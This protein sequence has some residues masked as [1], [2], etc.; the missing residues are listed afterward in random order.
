MGLEKEKRVDNLAKG[1]REALLDVCIGLPEFELCAVRD[2]PHELT[3]FPPGAPGVVPAKRNVAQVRQPWPDS[4]EAE[5]HER[6][7]RKQKQRNK[8]S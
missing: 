1:G 7:P 4:D 8:I 6:A 2:T 3:A 5:E